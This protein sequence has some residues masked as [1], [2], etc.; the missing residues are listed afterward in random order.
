MHCRCRTSPT[1]SLPLGNI[2]HLLAAV[3]GCHQ[4]IHWR[5]KMLRTCSLS[6]RVIPHTFTDIYVFS[7]H[8]SSIFSSTALSSSFFLSFSSF[9]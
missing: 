8:S 4:L 1:S 7:T 6:P 3:M 9:S 2:T 5:R